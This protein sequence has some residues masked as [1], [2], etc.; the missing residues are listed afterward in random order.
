ML[1]SSELRKKAAALAKKH[2]NER[3]K[4]NMQRQAHRKSSGFEC[5]F[6]ALLTGI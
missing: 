5:S 6:D 3:K 1:F 4:E 2:I